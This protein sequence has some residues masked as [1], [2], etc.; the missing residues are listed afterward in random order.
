MKKYFRNC[1]YPDFNNKC[2]TFGN[3]LIDE[4]KIK[5]LE[6][7]ESFNS[8]E[9]INEVINSCKQIVSERLSA[10][11]ENNF[12]I[13]ILSPGFI[14]IHMHEENFLS[15]GTHFVISEMMLRQGVTRRVR[16]FGDAGAVT[17]ILV[18][19]GFCMV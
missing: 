15:E 16:V 1:I 14:D 11:E 2:L 8:E 18:Y 9:D 10:E 17:E 12:N 4:G 6:C 5:N 3:V 13:N 7:I 19:Q